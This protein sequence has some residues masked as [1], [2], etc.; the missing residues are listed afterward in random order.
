MGG[1]SAS[2]YKFV[3]CRPYSSHTAVMPP[4]TRKDFS[5]AIFIADAKVMHSIK[6]TPIAGNAGGPSRNCSNTWPEQRAACNAAKVVAGKMNS[7]RRCTVRVD[8]ARPAD[9]VATACAKNVPAPTKTSPHKMC[10]RLS[11]SSRGRPASA[12]N[13]ALQKGTRGPYA[14]NGK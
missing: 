2:A 6:A 1:P 12:T 5:L 7:T 13:D 14:L 4:V 3:K 10:A 8:A 11:D 9:P